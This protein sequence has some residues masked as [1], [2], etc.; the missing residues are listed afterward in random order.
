M[1][2]KEIKNS[3]AV[4]VALCMSTAEAEETEKSLDELAR[5]LDTAGGEC[6]ARLIQNKEAPDVRTVIGSGKVKELKE[7]CVNNEADLVVF[8]GELS[9]SQIRNLE[10]ELDGPRVIDRSM[11][12][13]DI[14]ALHATT[15]DGKLQVELAQLKYT[16]PRLM[17][18]GAELSRLGG[19]I[20]TRGPGESKLESDRRH[21][22]RRI[23]ALEN[24]LAVLE[25]NRLTMRASRDKSGIAKA[26]IVGYTNAGKSTLLNRLT[27]AGI[28]AED[29]LFATLD[30]TTRKFTLP[31]GEQ[32]LLTDTVGFIRKLPHHLV[33]AFKS[34][35]DE[36]VYADILIVFIDASDSEFGA[37]LRVTRELLSE[38]GA[39]DKPTLFVFNKCDRGIAHS[40]ASVINPESDRHVLISAATGEGIDDF[41]GE[42]DKILHENTTRAT[43]VIPN[44]EQRALNTL[45][46]NATVESVEYG[47]TAVTVIAIV[48]AKTRGMMR[49][50]DTC[51]PEREEN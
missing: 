13:L 39:A 26:A 29:K 31:S 43:F 5:L 22:K 37:Q 19:G 42:L 6:F 23:T 34:T 35:L 15:G 7:L 47:D 38:L 33:K 30:P 2:N 51:P 25:K 40:I 10:D 45:Y 17:G 4:L 44:A 8:D 36:A 1:E 18:K 11:L 41:I 9:P 21:I 46:G 32:M 14:F 3:R 24:E 12:I 49:K 27:G 16:A 20:G 50:Y 48:D 28:L